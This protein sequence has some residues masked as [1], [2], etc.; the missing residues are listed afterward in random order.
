MVLPQNQIDIDSSP[1]NASNP[2]T[3][4]LLLLLVFTPMCVTTVYKALTD[5]TLKPLNPYK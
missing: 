2:I 5:S 3:F 4:L 1:C